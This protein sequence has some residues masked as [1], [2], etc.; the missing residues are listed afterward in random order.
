[1]YGIVVI[2]PGRALAD[3]CKQSHDFSCHMIWSR[4]SQNFVK[5]L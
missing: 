1:M 2:E 3:V 4:I 5:L